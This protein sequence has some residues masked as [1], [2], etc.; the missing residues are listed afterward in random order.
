MP[1]TAI[2]RAVTVYQDVKTTIDNQLHRSDDEI[3][4]VVDGFFSQPEYE[5]D[6]VRVVPGVSDHMAI[7]GEVERK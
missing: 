2:D 7:I 5:V 1:T 3:M 4:V 6:Q